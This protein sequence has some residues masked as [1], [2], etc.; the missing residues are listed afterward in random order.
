MGNEGVVMAMKRNGCVGQR[1]R[2]GR[3]KQEE[4]EEMK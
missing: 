1:D 3:R 2:E 4:K